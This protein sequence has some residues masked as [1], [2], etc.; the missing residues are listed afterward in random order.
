MNPEQKAKKKKKNRINSYHS[1][2]KR[3]G[4]YTF[5][6]K[7]LVKVL[8]GMGIL[9]L[10]LFL[11]QHF[12]PDFDT[13]MEA[14]LTHFK[15]LSIL[16]VFFISES[17]LGLIPPDIFI[18]WAQNFTYPY[19][20]V[21]LLAILSYLGGVVSYVIGNYIGKIPVVENWLNKKFV[22]SFDQIKKW[23]G[24]LIVFAAL[25][26][27]PFSPVCMAAG[28]IRFPL[29]TFFLLGTFRFVRFFLYAVVIYTV[30]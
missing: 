22:T 9:L 16:T 13:Q 6:L 29:T 4:V 7:N 19:A 17:I 25:F 20:M 8:I 11:F 14:L 5:F 15:P 23:G 24:I 12:V 2:Y 30:I 26:P 18:I 27:L 1:F 10:I 21:G 28:T 3:K